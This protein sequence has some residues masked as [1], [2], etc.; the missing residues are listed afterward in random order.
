MLQKYNFITKNNIEIEIREA[1][2]GDGE[3]VVEFHNR[4]GGQTN[5]LSFGK[6]QFL[7]S[8]EEEEMVLEARYSSDVAILIIATHNGTIVGSASV[9]SG[10]EERFRHVFSFGMVVTKEYWGNGIGTVLLEKLIEWCK[11]N[12]TCDKIS[13]QVRSDNERAIEIYT[14]LGFV[15]EG[16]LLNE[17]KING[18]YYN[19]M[20]MGLFL[21]KSNNSNE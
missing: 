6:N 9:D 13:L 12:C 15:K 3:A 20:L 18:K 21:D 17:P 5:N 14:A 10:M 7:Y 8:A 4:V 11:K 16:L 2:P 1:M 19:T